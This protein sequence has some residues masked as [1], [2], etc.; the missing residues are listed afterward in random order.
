M[1]TSHE[2]F[3]QYKAGLHYRRYLALARQRSHTLRTI[4]L[5]QK[6]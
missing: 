5:C 1:P 6:H 3:N 4:K 2:A